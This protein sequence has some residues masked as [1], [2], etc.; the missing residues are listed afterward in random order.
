NLLSN[1]DAS[2][3]DQVAERMLEISTGNFRTDYEETFAAGLGGALEEVEA[4]TR[5]QIISGPDVSFR[6]ASEAVAIARVTETVQNKE[7]PTGRTFE[8]LMEITLIDTV[9]GGWKAD[10]VEILSG[11]E[12]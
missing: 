5:G 4:S 1:Y 12:T 9:D 3:I 2:N 6:T 7:I 11:K 8:Y 10:R